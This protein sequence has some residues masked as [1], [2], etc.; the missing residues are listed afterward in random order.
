[1]INRRN[2]LKKSF[3][4]GGSV[5]VGGIFYPISKNKNLGS[6]IQNKFRPKLFSHQQKLMGTWV[7]ISCYSTDSEQAL[8]ALTL[9]FKEMET[10]DQLMSIH[11]VDSQLSQL[12]LQSGRSPLN[13]DPRIT[14]VLLLAN[15]YSQKSSGKYDVT[16]LPLMRLFGFY[17]H[18]PTQIP[19]DRQIAQVL[20]NISFANIQIQNASHLGIHEFNPIESSLNFNGTLG[21]IQRENASSIQLLNYGMAIDLG[22]IGKGYA[23]DRAV[24]ILKANGISSALVNAGGNIYALGAPAMDPDPRQTWTVGIR[25]PNNE[26]K[27]LKTIALRDQG[28]ATSGAYETFVNIKSKEIGHIFNAVTG[29]SMHD[30]SSTTA[31]ASSATVADILSTTSF[32][33]GGKQSRDLFPE[34]QFESYPS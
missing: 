10:I 13:V 4:I 14:E 1:M 23:V 22:S 17:G 27:I 29:K 3:I 2:F 32:I 12:N 9:A 34:A 30:Y 21:N 16:I 25:D 5:F 6:L 19:S 26:N 31:I 33:L 28:I 24:Q 8:K 18:V 11:K 15:K 7:S 20:E